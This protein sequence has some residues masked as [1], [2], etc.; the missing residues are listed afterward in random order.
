LTGRPSYRLIAEHNGKIRMT[1]DEDA[2]AGATINQKSFVASLKKYVLTPSNPIAGEQWSVDKQRKVLVNYWRAI[3]DLL[4]ELND[5]TSVIFKTNG[6][7]VQLG[8]GVR[9]TDEKNTG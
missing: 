8:V 6:L 7:Q 1:N 2:A 5:E 3:R 4:V 9:K